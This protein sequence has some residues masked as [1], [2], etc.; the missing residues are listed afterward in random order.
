MSPPM[1]I[2]E[3]FGAPDTYSVYRGKSR[4]EVEKPGYPEV[5]ALVR[6][7]GRGTAADIFAMPDP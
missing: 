3:D 5:S 7:G 4:N 2:Q 1:C 6:V